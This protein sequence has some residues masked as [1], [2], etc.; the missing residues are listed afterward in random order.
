MAEEKKHKLRTK[1]KHT[2][3]ILPEVGSTLN[4]IAKLAIDT[5]STAEIVISYKMVNGELTKDEYNTS[6]ELSADQQKLGK[7]MYGSVVDSFRGLKDGK[8]TV[9]FSSKYELIN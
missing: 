8:I 5:P 1:V 9:N 2:I 3:E 4:Q 6:G 7:I